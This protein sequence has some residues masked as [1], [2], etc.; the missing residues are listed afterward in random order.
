[1]NICLFNS[2]LIGIPKFANKA[3]KKCAKSSKCRKKHC[4]VAAFRIPSVVTFLVTRSAQRC[5]NR[6]FQQFPPPGSES[7]TLQTRLQLSIEVT[8][9]SLRR[10]CIL[11]RFIT[12]MSSFISYSSW[13][14]RMRHSPLSHKGRR[15]M[16]NLKMS[17]SRSVHHIIRPAARVILSLIS[18]L[19]S[20]FMP[21]PR[22]TTRTILRTSSAN[23]E[24][25]TA[26]HDTFI[27]NKATV[28]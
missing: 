19:I 22:Y 28:T 18:R 6:P 7:K 1:M 5:L 14:H 10:R 17:S 26:R 8:W 12:S 21:Q 27:K 24:N 13:F 9:T 3:L 11:I 23:L 15:L 2:L 20:V 25:A 16:L 4:I